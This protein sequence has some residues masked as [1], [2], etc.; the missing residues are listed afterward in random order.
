MFLLYK[1]LLFY[2]SN[3]NKEN[4]SKNLFKNAILR[5]IK[6]FYFNMHS[7]ALGKHKISHSEDSE[8]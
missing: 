6:S 2:N 3:K 4:L 8:S 1:L 7:K 5:I